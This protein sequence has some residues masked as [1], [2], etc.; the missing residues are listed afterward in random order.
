[1]REGLTA[2]RNR[3]VAK[4][5][6]VPDTR[7]EPTRTSISHGS[8]PLGEEIGYRG[9]TASEAAGITYRQLD[10]WARTGLIEPSVRTAHGT[11]S[12]RLY[13]FRDILLLTLVKRLLDTGISLQQIKVTVQHLGDRNTEELAQV[14]LMSD[15]KNI[16]EATSPDEIVDQLAAG[17]GLFGIALG[18]LWQEVA[19]KL[20]E[21]PAVRTEVTARQRFVVADYDRLV[22]THNKADDTVVVLR[23]PGEDPRAILR[24]ARLVLP[25]D[26]YEQLVGQLAA[27]APFPAAGPDHPGIVPILALAV[28]ADSAQ[29]TGKTGD[30]AGALRLYE[31]VLPDE[32][33]VLGPDHPETLATRA[34]IA[35]WTRETGDAA[36]ALRLYEDLLPDEVRVL[37][38]DHPET[39]AT[40]AAIA[41]WT[42]ET[43]DAAG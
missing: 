6:V 13:S 31:D 2:G 30:A 26:L 19:G 3:R 28:R 41:R 21:F 40:R 24:V 22:V 43:G 34:A 35:R 29:L 33:R 11:G 14:T 37:G 20:A 7:V 38:P 36:G 39:L 15:G 9:H 8:D 27:P 17:Q 1:M 10:Y 18:R 4:R 23:P 32:V 42:R 12:Q 16:Y 5:N 25:G